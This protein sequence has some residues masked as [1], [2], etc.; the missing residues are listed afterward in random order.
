MGPNDSV[1]LKKVLPEGWTVEERDGSRTR[2]LA[3]Y[4]EGEVF[5]QGV[6]TTAQGVVVEM[7]K[8]HLNEKN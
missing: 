2:L 3:L 8:Q 4:Q 6:G 5:L 7:I 1:L